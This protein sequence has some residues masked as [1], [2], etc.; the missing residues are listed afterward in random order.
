M[1]AKQRN[2]K[3]ILIRATENKRCVVFKH[4]QGECSTQLIEVGRQPVICPQ[5]VRKRERD[6]GAG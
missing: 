2:L 4:A 3:P 1:A 5:R 6:T